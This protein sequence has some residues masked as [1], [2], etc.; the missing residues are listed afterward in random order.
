MIS[1]IANCVTTPQLMQQ[2]TTLME[3][4]VE[5]GYMTQN[6]VANYQAT[7]QNNLNWLAANIVEIDAVIK[8]GTIP[9][10]TV[11]PTTAPTTNSPP[12]SSQLPTTTGGAQTIVISSIVLLSSIAMKI[13]M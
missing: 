12:T 13:F 7:A 1:Y 6:S 4:L 5:A 2:F 11:V 10:P 3:M 8:D 9:T